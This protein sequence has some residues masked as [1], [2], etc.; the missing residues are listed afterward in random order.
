MKEGKNNIIQLG[1]QLANYLQLATY[2]VIAMYCIACIKL[3]QQK[4]FLD[5][6]VHNQS[7]YKVYKPTMFV[8][9]DLLCK[10]SLSA[11]VCFFY[12]N[13]LGQRSTTNFTGNVLYYMHSTYVC[14]YMLSN[15]IFRLNINE[16]D[17]NHNEFQ[18]SLL[19]Y[20]DDQLN[21]NCVQLPLVRLCSYTIRCCNQLI[22]TYIPQLSALGNLL[23]RL[24][25]QLAM[26]FHNPIMHYITSHRMLRR[27]LSNIMHNVLNI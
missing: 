3:W 9:D 6:V 17:N 15:N 27:L 19:D 1:N 25:S 24:A 8:L 12:Q 23:N 7:S 4:R 10:S 22:H 2:L 14:S 16:G 13:V 21:R 26:Q 11:Y 18:D 20:S 5:L